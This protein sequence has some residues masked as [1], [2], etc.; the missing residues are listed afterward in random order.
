MRILLTNDDGIYAPGMAA[1]YQAM[2]GL[3]ELHVV[4]P[5]SVRSAM[6]HAVTFHRPMETRTVTVND[7]K[8]QPLF[9]GIAVDGQPAD[10]VKLAVHHLVPQP[11]DLVVSGINSGANVGV[12]VFYSGTVGAAREAAIWGMPAIAVSLHI[13]RR[14]AIEW[15]RASQLTRSILNDMLKHVIE[16]HTLLNLNLPVLDDGRKPKGVRVVPLCTSRIVEDYSLASDPVTSE[17]VANDAITSESPAS[18]STIN[19]PAASPVGSAMSQRYVASDIFDFHR[20]DP[21]TDVD[22]LFAGYATITPL[23][24]DPTCSKG[25]NLWSQRLLNSMKQHV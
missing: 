2:A 22:C 23:S 18:Q 11:I 19:Q 25:V 21:D 6:S 12:N 4:A 1:L 13:A 8:G 20:R 17:T 3:G 15:P 5:L 24:F 10:C 14:D 9:T 16:P 7:E